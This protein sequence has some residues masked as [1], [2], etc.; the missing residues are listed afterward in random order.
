MEHTLEELVQF[1]ESF[2]ACDPGMQTAKDLGIYGKELPEA[3]AVL[4][5]NNQEQY[6]DFIKNI[7]DTE[8]YV[9]FNGSII[10][11][12]TYQVFNPITG[13]HQEYQDEESARGGIADIQR[14]ILEQ[15]PVSVTQSITNEN[16][17]STWIPV[18]ISP[19]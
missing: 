18:T 15:Y 10:T 14:Q 4:E 19:L 6:A 7:M 9:R 11:M 17:D 12:G 1:L 5:A 13:Q 3:L 16:G 2:G 8:E